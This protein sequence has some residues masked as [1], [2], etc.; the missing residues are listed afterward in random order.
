MIHVE[1]GEEERKQIS[2]KVAKDREKSIRLIS[3]GGTQ[4]RIRKVISKGE[5]MILAV[6]AGVKKTNI[7]NQIESIHKR[8]KNYTRTMK[9]ILNNERTTREKGNNKQQRRQV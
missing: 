5:G 4:R 7:V 3:E 8:R 6:E 1:S 2:R 9:T